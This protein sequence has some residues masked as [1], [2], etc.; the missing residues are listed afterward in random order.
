MIAIYIGD[1]PVK[2][3]EGREGLVDVIRPHLDEFPRDERGG[4]SS[5]QLHLVARS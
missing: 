3:R 4:P 1:P 2:P 5:T